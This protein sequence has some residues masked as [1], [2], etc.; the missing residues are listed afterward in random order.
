MQSRG[1]NRSYFYL[2]FY[3]SF[4]RSDLKYLP[5]GISFVFKPADSK[6]RSNSNAKP[7][8]WWCFRNPRN[9]FSSLAE[10]VFIDSV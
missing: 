10:A 7:S 4:F 5:R 6:Y 1:I 2:S 8:T 3:L 9:D